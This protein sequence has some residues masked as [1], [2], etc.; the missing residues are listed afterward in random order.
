MSIG[1]EKI[2]E[3]EKNNEEINELKNALQGSIDNHEKSNNN[4]IQR[5]NGEAK[6]SASNIEVPLN[7]QDVF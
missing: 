1:I 5:N 3:E 2:K 7:T 4:N 6:N